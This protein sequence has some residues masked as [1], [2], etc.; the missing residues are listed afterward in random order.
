MVDAKIVDKSRFVHND[1]Y[2]RSSVNS[3]T[4]SQA[5]KVNENNKTYPVQRCEL[6]FTIT[7]A[8][9]IPVNLTNK[10]LKYEH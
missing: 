2:N 1:A 3:P 7:R 5:F 9:S 6:T 8:G 4:A 10:I